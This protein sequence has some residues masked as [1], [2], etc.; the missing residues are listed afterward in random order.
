MATTLW[1]IMTIINSAPPNVFEDP[2][3]RTF[4]GRGS[5]PWDTMPPPP[6]IT[7]ANR[8]SVITSLLAGTVATPAD[9]VGLLQTAAAAG[10]CTQQQVW[11]VLTNGNDTTAG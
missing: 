9:V 5:L 8:A 3:G 2:N 4:A 11:R 1:A 7:A 10:S 6:P